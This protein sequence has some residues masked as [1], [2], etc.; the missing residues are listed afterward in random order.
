[1]IEINS[2]FNISVIVAVFGA[3]ILYFGK[4]MSDINVEFHEKL[5]YYIV[6]AIYTSVWI[7]IPLFAIAYPLYK[8]YFSSIQSSDFFDFIFYYLPLFI[9]LLLLF[10]I[11]ENRKLKSKGKT[12]KTSTNCYIKYLGNSISLWFFSFFVIIS[13]FY[14]YTFIEIKFQNFVIISV[15]TFFVLTMIAMS[16]AYKNN[17]YP[18]V[19]IYFKDNSLPV[20]GTVLKYSDFVLI[21]E[22]GK[23]LRINK[24]AIL[25]IEKN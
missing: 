25:K 6:G 10:N 22:N 12:S 2:L 15:I 21:L 5:D 18:N 4:I 19:R 13:A 11:R 3:M 23:E 7:I 16:I 14:W 1:M 17:T 24:D 8:I 20:E 9:A